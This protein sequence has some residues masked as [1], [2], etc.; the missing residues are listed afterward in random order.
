M[1]DRLGESSSDHT[2]NCFT[3]NRRS[4][5]D[6]C[7]CERRFG[8]TGRLLDDSGVPIQLPDR[9]LFAGQSNPP[10]ESGP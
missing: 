9:S 8:S 1:T 4:A 5:L 10:L 7:M 3:H 6:R 2:T